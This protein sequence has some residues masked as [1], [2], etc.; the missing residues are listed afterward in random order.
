MPD[1]MTMDE[2]R[3]ILRSIRDGLRTAEP[4]SSDQRLAWADDL[5]RVERR[6]YRRPAVRKAPVQSR[7]VDE[8]MADRIR[9]MAQRDYRLTQAQI[10][11][12]LNINPGRVSEVLAGER[13]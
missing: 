2:A 9:G 3:A 11:A 7:P 5:D 12:A 4:I 13:A 1:D 8:E 6:T 10:A